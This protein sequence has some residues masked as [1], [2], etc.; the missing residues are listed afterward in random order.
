L[1]SRAWIIHYRKPV[2]GQVSGG[3]SIDPETGLW[4]VTLSSGLA[5]NVPRGA[6]VQQDN[7]ANAFRWFLAGHAAMPEATSLSGFVG[8]QRRD[9]TIVVADHERWPFYIDQQAGFPNGFDSIRTWLKLPLGGSSDPN[10]PVFFDPLGEEID[11]TQ[12]PTFSTTSKD[13]LSSK[14]NYPT[15][16]T[17]TDNAL[18]RDGS[19]ET[20]AS[21]GVSDVITL[22]F[23][24]ATS[25]FADDDTVAST[26]HVVTQ[27][28]IDFTNAGGGTTFGQAN[29]SGGVNRTFRFTQAAARDYNATVRCV[30][31]GGSGGSV[32]EVWW[33]HDLETD[34]D[35]D[36]D[37]DVVVGGGADVGEILEYAE[38]VVKLPTTSGNSILGN[39][40]DASGSLVS[41][42]WRERD[43][44]STDWRARPP[45]VMAGLQ[46]YL[47]GE[48]GSLNTIDSA[49]YDRADAFYSDS[50]YRLNF[51]LINRVNTW[52]DLEA[53]L[54]EQSRAHMF[55]GPSGHEILY[56]QEG[57][58]L[59]D[60]AVKQSFRLPGVP[61]ANCRRGGAPIMERTAVSTAINIFEINWHFDYAP[62]R[63]KYLNT[64]SAQE[65]DS[66]DAFGERRDPRGVRRYWALSPI[67]G[68][69]TYSA[70]AQVSGLTQFYADRY[71]YPSTRFS[72][73]TAWIAHGLD[74][75]SV[76]RVTYK[77]AENVYRN[78]ICEVEEIA[79]A[80]MNAETFAVVCRGV[81]PPSRGYEPAVVWT[82]LFTDV[83]DSWVE[84]ITNTYDTWGDYFAPSGSA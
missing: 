43:L 56:M 7:M 54:A 63:S 51:V 40:L 38:V 19:T 76:V 11:V 67:A 22:T 1:I 39:A 34:V 29:G 18:A 45:A 80:P 64:I 6:Y 59:G 69:P 27:G 79:A 23:N 49:S 57:S 20:G 83:G 82:D 72:V 62:G 81:M 21:L 65:A 74:R 10:A 70:A 55:Y 28:N 77:V 8:F 37:N 53:Q 24:S 15:S 48:E 52:T 68:H 31:A 30:G 44:G 2:Y 50:D 58:G 73:D 3:A 66:V 75:G 42:P 17:G 14:L 61:G 5:A 32:V 78:V 71:A 60:I 36:R 9:G 84:R 25:P 4:T 47:L 46:S 13:R 26:L 41:N 12:Q 16:G 35:L 33:E